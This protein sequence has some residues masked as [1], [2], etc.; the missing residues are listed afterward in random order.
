[1]VV[2]DR[3]SKVA[4]FNPL[5]ITYSASEVAHFFIRKIM[6]LHGVPKNI[7][8]DKYV[9][10]TSRFWK[11]LFVGLGTKLEFSRNYHLQKDG[12]T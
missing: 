2:V 3:L 11:E 1:M 10:F 7:I 5:K 8:L 9:K 4:H 6:R 12:Q